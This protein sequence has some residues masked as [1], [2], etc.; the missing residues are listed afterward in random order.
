MKAKKRSGKGK[1]TGK[2]GVKDLPP[3][4]AQSVKG[5]WGLPV[6]P[7]APKPTGKAQPSDFSFVHTVDKASP[8]LL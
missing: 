4:K 2:R 3:A 7:P 5:G 8:V 6:V 1:P